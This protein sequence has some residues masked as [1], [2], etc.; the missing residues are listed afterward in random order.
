MSISEA[1]DRT[2]TVPSQSPIAD[3]AL[4][5]SFAGASSLEQF[6]AA[7]LAIL[8][9]QIERVLGAFLIVAGDSDNTYVPAAVWPDP[10]RDMAYLAS[11]AQRALVERKGIVETGLSPSDA[12]RRGHAHAAYPVDVSGVVHGAIV[13]HL[14]ARSDT[15][16]QAALRLIHW[17]SAWL[18][19]LFRQREFEA[20]RAAVDRLSLVMDLVAAVA[21]ERRF[22]TASLTLVNEVARTLDCERVSLGSERGGHV[23]IDAMSHTATFDAKSELARS[24]AETMDETMDLGA[25]IVWPASGD[26]AL[27]AA[28]HA[29]LSHSN[30]DSALLSVPLSTNGMDWGVVLLERRQDKPF[31]A[32]TVELVRTLAMLLGPMLDLRRLN[33]RGVIRRAYDASGET[34]RAAFG[35]R[36]PG[37]KLVGSLGLALLVAVSLVQGEHRVSARTVIEGE[38]QRAI[39][40]PFDGYVAESHVRAGDVVRAGQILVHLDDRDLRLDYTKWEAEREQHLRKH[41]Q[42][43]AARERG[44]INVLSAQVNQAEAQLQLVAEK[45]TRATI[46]APFDG[47]VVSGDLSQLLGSPVEQG[48]V[49][50]E[51][52]P[53]DAYR[54]VLKVD[55]R[56]VAYV[57]PGQAGQLILSGI[58]GERMQFKVLRITPV[59]TA[60]EG[61]NYFRA[62]ASLERTTERLRPGM[63]GV[64]KVN[65]GEAALVWIWTR[66][67]VDWM[68][69]TFWTLTP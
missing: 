33:D 53:L 7:W 15:E 28:A 34:L 67:L 56:D 25:P 39:V 20:K 38:V 2:T 19:D 44:T 3:S 22:R 29:V 42:A 61:H 41:R 62:E 10:A 48:K 68:R 21:Q 9:L 24:L 46:V 47:F 66:R 5:E 57:R 59:A 45:L 31:D 4:W 36:H 55:E 35:P 43:L 54:V 1:A 69:Y 13:L 11:I 64:S 23:R 52:A 17:A 50:F 30:A 8:C 37:L 32:M 63:E 65:V 12:D 58:P 26:T 6:Y 49:L 14:A 51:V 16:L 18:V 27:M 60:E 40:A